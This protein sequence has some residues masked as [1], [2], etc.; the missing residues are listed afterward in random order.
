M[1]PVALVTD[2]HSGA[3]SITSRR[4]L[5]HGGRAGRSVG[6]DV[7][8]S[9]NAVPGTYPIDKALVE[10]VEG[11]SSSSKTQPGR[12]EHIGNAIPVK[13]AQAIG[14]AAIAMLDAAEDGFQLVGGGA[15]WVERR[16]ANAALDVLRRALSWA[17][18]EGLLERNP[19]EGIRRNSEPPRER[20][21]LRHTWACQ[22]LLAGER[23]ED[24]SLVLGHKSVR[25]TQRSYAHVLWTPAARDTAHRVGERIAAV[26]G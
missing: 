22:A 16:R 23:L 13:A 2:D 12:R 17:C 8:S 20:Y 6:S 26:V 7:G 19:A 9:A 15:I 1:E 3:D 4:R 5:G 21:T 24:V 25:V 14:E 18:D 10:R 11:P